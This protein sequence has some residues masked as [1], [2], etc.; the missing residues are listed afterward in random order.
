M[1]SWKKSITAAFNVIG[2]SIMWWIIGLVIAIIGF[3][4]INNP[5]NVIKKEFILADYILIFT[6][7]ILMACGCVLIITGFLASFMKVFGDLIAE[8]IH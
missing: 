2:Y 6:G 5:M 1:V 8:E 3:S 7:F 4:I